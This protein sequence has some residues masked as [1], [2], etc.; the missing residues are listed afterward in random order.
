MDYKQNRELIEEILKCS[1]E[2]DYCAT[3]CLDE[4]D[5]DMLKDCIKINLMCAEVCRATAIAISRGS[6]HAGHLLKECIEICEQCSDECGK[7]EHGHCKECSR[8]CENCAE[9]CKQA[10]TVH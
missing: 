6:E 3:A 8:T 10:E 9:S 7:H 4:Q 5:I 2:C 1:A